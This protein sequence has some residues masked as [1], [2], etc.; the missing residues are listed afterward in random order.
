MNIFSQIH[1][2]VFHGGGG[3]IWSEVYNWPIWHRKFIFKKM[4]D[5]F[6]DKTGEND[7]QKYLVNDGVDLKG[8]KPQIPI[9]AQQAYNVRAPRT[10]K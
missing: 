8:P 6:D 5:H 7:S 1:E 9:E 3:Y 10:K 2:I 4:K